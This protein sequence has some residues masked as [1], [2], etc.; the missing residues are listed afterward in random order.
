MNQFIVV[1]KGYRRKR[2]HKNKKKTS[3]I[4][5]TKM[6]MSVVVYFS[7]IEIETYKLCF[8]A[9]H[10]RIEKEGRGSHIKMTLVEWR[11]SW[12]AGIMQISVEMDL[13]NKNSKELEVQLFCNCEINSKGH[14]LNFNCLWWDAHV[15]DP[16]I[17]WWWASVYWLLLYVNCHEE[18]TEESEVWMV[19]LTRRFMDFRYE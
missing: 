17:V 1:G 2:T 7:T 18:H 6:P 8:C 4:K 16:K 14:T 10:R 15:F 5:S 3:T 12:A 9:R 11:R 19:V 13:R